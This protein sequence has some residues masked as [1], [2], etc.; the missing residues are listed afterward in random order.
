VKM[1]EVQ[2]LRLHPL[3]FDLHWT[4]GKDTSALAAIPEV[5]GEL[6]FQGTA[7]LAGEGMRLQGHVHAD[8]APACARCLE[9]IAMGVE[10][11]FDLLY[12]PEA[13]LGESAEVEIHAADTELG[14]FAGAGVDLEEVA[15]EQVLLALPM[16]PL[17][18]PDC[19]GL[20][21]RCGANLNAGAC[22][23]PPPADD[24]WSALKSLR[25][26]GAKS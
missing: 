21:P 10:R 19:R 25:R 5:T 8:I 22:A 26:P 3:P 9:P 15:R 23:C 12:Q 20:C 6:R 4:A 2:E 14:F 17:C 11:D 16:Q 18:R 24:R 1:I 13:L 7:R